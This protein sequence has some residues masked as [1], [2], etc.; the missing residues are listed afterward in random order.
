MIGSL[1]LS[2]RNL[3]GSVGDCLWQDRLIQ[4]APVVSSAFSSA[5]SSASFSAR[6]SLTLF[7]IK[8][9]LSILNIQFATRRI[10]GHEL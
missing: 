3:K 1:K 5:V 6:M 8:L 4:Y 2:L 7:G 10:F 9:I